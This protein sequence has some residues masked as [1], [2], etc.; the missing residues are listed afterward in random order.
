MGRT[1]RWE[2][3][4]RPGVGGRTGSGAGWRSLLMDMMDYT[5]EVTNLVSFGVL[6]S[7]RPTTNLYLFLF[8]L[9]VCWIGLV[10]MEWVSVN[11]QQIVRRWTIHYLRNATRILMNCICLG[12]AFHL[13]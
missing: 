5:R 6:L 8:L 2:W 11:Q 3:S 4:T 9:L 10:S 1:P 12:V 7:A 13:T